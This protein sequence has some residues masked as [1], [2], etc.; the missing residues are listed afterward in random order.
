M[1]ALRNFLEVLKRHRLDRG[2]TLGLLQTLVGRNI[3]SVQ[4]SFVCRGLTWRQ[5]AMVLKKARWPKDAVRDLHMDP[6]SMPPRDRQQFWY[7]AISLARIDSEEA[8]AAAKV[9]AEVLEPL[10]YRVT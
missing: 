9:L 8:S 1:D 2:H 7:T 10:G 3:Q 5:L 4:G 6:A